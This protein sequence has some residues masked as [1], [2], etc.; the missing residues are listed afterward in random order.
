[1]LGAE[2]G[3]EGR[4]AFRHLRLGG[5]VEIDQRQTRLNP[6][7]FATDG[8]ALVNLD[9]S[10]EHAVRRGPGRFDIMVRNALNTSYRDFLS[11]FKEF[12]TGPGINVIV[13]ASAGVW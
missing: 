9:L 11:R 13:K 6:D 12:A 1:V 7:D 10:F 4:G 3:T 8:Y 5:E 2:I